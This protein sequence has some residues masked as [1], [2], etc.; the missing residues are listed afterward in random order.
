MLTDYQ[1]GI[2]GDSLSRIKCNRRRVDRLRAIRRDLE[3]ERR[4]L[5]DLDV[6]R[7][8]MPFAARNLMTA[9]R[10]VSKSPAWHMISEFL[11]EAALKNASI[12]PVSK[13]AYDKLTA[14]LR[15]NYNTQLEVIAL[16][17]RDAEVIRA[18]LGGEPNWR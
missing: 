3:D 4:R 10:P 15:R 1:V 12:P 8:T 17:G 11:R 16:L 14:K 18:A 5:I 6:S 9:I 7:I 2:V 13:Q